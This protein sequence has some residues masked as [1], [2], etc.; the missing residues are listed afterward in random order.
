MNLTVRFRCTTLSYSLFYLSLIPSSACET[1]TPGIWFFDEIV[2][3][4]PTTLHHHIILCCNL[5]NFREPFDIYVDYVVVQREIHFIFTIK[6]I[7]A[8][9]NT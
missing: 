7:S 5:N 2:Y 3:F 1:A 4:L 8:N 9:T 6:K